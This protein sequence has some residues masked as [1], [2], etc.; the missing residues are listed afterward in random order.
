MFSNMC[1]LDKRL[2]EQVENW[3]PPLSEQAWGLKCVGVNSSDDDSRLQGCEENTQTVAK[4]VN[5]LVKQA[6]AER[7]YDYPELK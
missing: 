3:K 7:G 5:D 2:A 1:C 4:K 6:C